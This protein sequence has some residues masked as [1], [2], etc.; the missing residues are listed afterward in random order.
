MCRKFIICIYF[1][2]PERFL[3]SYKLKNIRFL[4]SPILSISDSYCLDFLV[5]FP[6][7]QCIC[8]TS[9]YTG[10][11]SDSEIIRELFY[12]EY[13]I[14]WHILLLN[15]TWYWV[16]SLYTHMQILIWK[17]EVKSDIMNLLRHW[18]KVTIRG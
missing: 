11:L 13:F 9:K 12:W 5:P 10:S 14:L 18:W 16:Y 2:C 17:Y 4:E 7:S 1:V 15:K 6:I 3:A 8:M